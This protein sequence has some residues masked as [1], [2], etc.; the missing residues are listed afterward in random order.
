MKLLNIGAISCLSVILGSCGNSAEIKQKTQA[1]YQC[2]SS[3]ESIKRTFEL[4]T[5]EN[6]LPVYVSDDNRET[7]ASA[8]WY[9]QNKDFYGD[10]YMG[11]EDWSPIADLSDCEQML[12]T[13]E[14][15]YPESDVVNQTRDFLE[16]NQVVLKKY[17]DEQISESVSS[18]YVFV[19]DAEECILVNSYPQAF[20][21]TDFSNT[22]DFV[23]SDFRITWDDETLTNDGREPLWRP[24]PSVEETGCMEKLESFSSGFIDR[25]FLANDDILYTVE[26][27]DEDMKRL[28]QIKEVVQNYNQ[29]VAAQHQELKDDGETIPE[30]GPYAPPVIYNLNFDYFSQDQLNDLAKTCQEADLNPFVNGRGETLISMPESCELIQNL[31]G[32]EVKPPI[33]QATCAVAEDLFARLEE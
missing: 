31:C 2:I 8:D 20:V 22:E 5:E 15:D 32:S 9:Q 10:I 33:D 23:P 7:Y 13:L 16:F 1:V 26:E 25:A 30:K 27:H 17:N 21:S 14:R 6:R 3:P 11:E 29:I 18:L 19:S 4:A 12:V 24:I 28:T